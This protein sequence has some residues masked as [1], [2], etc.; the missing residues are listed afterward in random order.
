MSQN[1]EIQ[2]IVALAAEGKRAQA[3]AALLSLDPQ[4]KD[5]RTRL[6]F[7]DAA[8]S[9]LSPVDDNRRILALIMEGIKITDAS[10]LSDLKA[11][12]MARAADSS[13]LPVATR[14]H[15]MSMLKLAPRWFEFATEAD[16]REYESLEVGVKA[17]EKGVDSSLSQAMTI[18]EESEDKRVQGLVLMA[19]ARVENARYMQYKGDCM[20]SRFRAKLWS[21][22]KFMRSP[23]FEYL[24]LFK[25]GDAW[26]LNAF[27]K[28]FTQSSLKA[29]QLFEEIDDSAAAH[30]YHNLANDLRTA[31]RFRR[32]KRYLAKGREIARRHNDLQMLRQIEEMERIISEKNRDIPDYLHGERRDDL[33]TR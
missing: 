4:I 24:I 1:D 13:M 19:K 16:K 5:A 6:T 33:D 12:F 30:A 25:N 31:H 10:G 26:K 23:F 14:R 32:A 28:A 9:I 8:L 3:R 7:I 20:R 22:F 21:R 17:L 15:R 27:V 18:A 29:A 11:C 2:K